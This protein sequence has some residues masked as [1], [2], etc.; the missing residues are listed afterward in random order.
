MKFVAACIALLGLPA[1][2][3][4][5]QIDLSWDNCILADVANGEPPATGDKTFACMAPQTYR[6]HG[7][8]KSPSDIPDFVGMDIAI[9]LQQE[10]PGTLVPF[11]HYEGCNASGIAISPD[12]STSGTTGDGNACAL[13]G[14]PWGR[15]EDL[16]FIGIIW[17]TNNSA[18]C[19]RVVRSEAETAGRD[20]A[21]LG[22][23]VALGGWT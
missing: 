2:P 8:F 10:D 23:K 1:S 3:A 5:A 16:G 12:K 13:F 4:F 6:L 18:S 22:Q 14:T 15:V 19:A 21:N 9:D 7:C 17:T 20:W 11:Y